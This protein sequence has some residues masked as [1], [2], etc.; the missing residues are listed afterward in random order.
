MGALA[1]PPAA[2]KLAFNPALNEGGSFSGDRRRKME[3]GSHQVQ[4]N[5]IGFNDERT[6]FFAGETTGGEKANV[7]GMHPAFR[8]AVCGIMLIVM[9]SGASCLDG[10]ERR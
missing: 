5:E 3:Q 4:S 6:R 9:F 8:D 7:Q 1:N 10:K 2:F